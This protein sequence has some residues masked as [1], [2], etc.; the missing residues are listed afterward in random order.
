M[1]FQSRRQTPALLVEERLDLGG[2]V[3]G[4]P[5]YHVIGHE[6]LLAVPRESAFG[7]AEQ[8]AHV[9][10]VQQLVSVKRGGLAVHTAQPVFNPV[11]PFHNLMKHHLEGLTVC[12]YH[13]TVCL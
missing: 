7:N 6:F 11:E 2:L 10:V 3:I 1:F 9:L 13:N 12:L 5:V 4:T 8:L